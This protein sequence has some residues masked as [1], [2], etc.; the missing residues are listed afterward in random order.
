MNTPGPVWQ[1]IGL[2]AT[3]VG[4][5][6]SLCA[7]VAA[8]LA[9]GQAKRAVHETRRMARI[10]EAGELVAELQQL[11]SSLSRGDFAAVAA[12][13]NKTRGQIVRYLH[14]AADVNA[15]GSV[16]RDGLLAARTQLIRITEVATNIRM[17]ADNKGTQIRIALGELSESLNIVAGRQRASVVSTR[18]VTKENQ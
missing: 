5:A 15:L 6:L 14:E 12:Q 13:A 11:E 17:K 16:E 18:E 3:F 2:L 8:W 9:R 4:A 1:W 7:V 10:I